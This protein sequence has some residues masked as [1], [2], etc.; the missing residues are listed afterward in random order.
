MGSHHCS[1]IWIIEEIWQKSSFILK[2]LVAF[3]LFGIV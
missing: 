1:N 2:I 3:H